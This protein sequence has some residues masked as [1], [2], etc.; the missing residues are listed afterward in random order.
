M[1][2]LICMV[3]AALYAINR[4]ILLPAG[5]PSWYAW[6]ANDVLGGLLFISI[7][8]GALSHSPLPPLRG[9]L[10][11]TGLML[12]CGVFWEYITPLYLPRSVSDPWDLLAYWLG[13]MAYLFILFFYKRSASSNP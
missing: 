6:H 9:V 2:R 11:V 8:N 3:V 7:V 13:G 10:P 1:H 12:L 4:F 5:T